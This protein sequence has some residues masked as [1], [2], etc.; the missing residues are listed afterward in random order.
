[1]TIAATTLDSTAAD[2]IVHRRYAVLALY[3]LS[4]F[5]GIAQLVAPNSSLLYLASAIAFAT[6]ATL[7][8][9]IDRRILAKPRLPILQLL[10]FFTWPIAALIHLLTSRGL[11]GIG[12]WLIHA[13]GLF[14]TMCLTYFPALFLLYWMGIL[15]LD[16][17]AET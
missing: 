14:A 7:W 1:M 13:V 5:W 12:H 11:R 17:L 3:G 15:D 10:F 6:S 8:F 16:A 4:A 2:R 9:T